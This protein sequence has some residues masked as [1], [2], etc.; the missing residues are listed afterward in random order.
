M[1]IDLTDINSGPPS[2]PDLYSAIDQSCSLQHDLKDVQAALAYW[3]QVHSC[4]VDL[5]DAILGL[6]PLLWPKATFTP[7]ADLKKRSVR[8]IADLVDL[9]ALHKAAE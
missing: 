1:K 5:E 3:Q 8:E 2:L 9:E 7:F 4:L 6:E